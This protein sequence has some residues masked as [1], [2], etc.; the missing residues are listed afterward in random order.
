MYEVIEFAGMFNQNPVDEFPNFK[1]A[2]DYVKEM[3]SLEEIEGMPVDITFNGST[4]Y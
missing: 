3:Y 4:E 2:R 1:E